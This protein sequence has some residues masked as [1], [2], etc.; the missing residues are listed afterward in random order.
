MK[1]TQILSGLLVLLAIS[2]KQGESNNFADSSVG[3][4]SEGKTI[5]SNDT[6][7]PGASILAFGPDNVLFVGDSK[8][9]KIYAIP[10]QAEELKDAIPYNME[11]FDRKMA[12]E[13]GMQARDIIINDMKI[14]P[15]SQEAYV[16]LKL[17]LLS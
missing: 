3:S 1:L 5:L 15:L 7:L 17:G 12:E 16:S 2:C 13:L 4:E 14:H 10:T 6:K 9:A 8:G 11:G